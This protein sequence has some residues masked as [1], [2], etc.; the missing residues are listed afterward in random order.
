MQLISPIT[1]TQFINTFA[2]IEMQLVHLEDNAMDVSRLA[3]DWLVTTVVHPCK[4][5]I[6]RNEK[7]ISKKA[8]KLSIPALERSS[9]KSC[10]VGLGSSTT[11]FLLT[12]PIQCSE[13]NILRDLLL[14]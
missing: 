2:R 5:K 8:K 7:K 9:M 14:F 13:G 10:M 11:M 3:T 4:K 12:H 6:K 1:Q